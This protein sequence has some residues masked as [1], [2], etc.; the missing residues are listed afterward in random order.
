MRL[1]P[2][3]LARTYHKQHAEKEAALLM[4]SGEEALDPMRQE[5]ENV[6]AIKRKFT[7]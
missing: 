3:H 4:E 6:T 5:R 2:T 7:R 1:S